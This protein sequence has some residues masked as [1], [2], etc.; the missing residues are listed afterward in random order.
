[1]N[2]AAKE[3]LTG[4]RKMTI[5]ACICGI[6]LISK[7]AFAQ[8]GLTLPYQEPANGPSSGISG[9]FDTNVV[10]EKHFVSDFPTLSIDYGLGRDLTIGTS[11]LTVISTAQAID[12]SK[13][14][15]FQFFN[16]KLRYRLLSH[17]GWTATLTGYY[18][19]LRAK[20]RQ[21]GATTYLPAA[22][23]NAARE[24]QSGSAGV[25]LLVAQFTGE[26]GAENEANFTRTDKLY[27]LLSGWWRPS[28]TNKTELELLATL[29]TPTQATELSNFSR[30]DVSQS[31]FSDK[32]YSGFLRGLLSWRSSQTWLL[33]AGVIWTPGSTSKFIPVLAAHHVAG[34][35]S[36]PPA[37]TIQPTTDAD[38]EE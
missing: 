21:T 20:G 31:C 30:V 24:L 1:V 38:N 25:S 11:L 35:F 27:R 29:C 6:A 4:S 14:K 33:S 37:N 17:S 5:L 36:R 23:F 8:R 15:P 22:T 13:D 26:S 9:F 10:E 32:L 3:T 19:Y 28:I 34:F 18:A 2:S 7:Q 16:G 12:N